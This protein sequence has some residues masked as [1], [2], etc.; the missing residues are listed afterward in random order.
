M[1]GCEVKNLGGNPN[2]G[3]ERVL[4]GW[5]GLGA[6]LGAASAL[7]AAILAGL[8]SLGWVGLLGAAGGYVIGVG[9]GHAVEWFDRLKEQDP[10]EI[11]ISGLIVC[12]G[13][14]TG[15]PPFN[16]NDWTFNVGSLSVT[17]PT[18]L[19]VNEVRTRPAPPNW[20]AFPSVDDPSEVD[21]L[22]CEIGSHIGDF[23][24]VGGAVG[25]VAGA[26]AG[27][28]I[29]AALGCLVLGIFTFGLGC[30]IAILIG[31]AVGALVGLAAGNAIGAG[32]GWIADELSDFDRRGKAIERGCMLFLTGSWV[33]DAGHQHNEIHD[34]ERATLIDCGITSS[35]RSLKLA[36]AVGTGR[37]P[38]DRDP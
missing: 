5:G 14:N 38:Q 25:S 21:V 9:I 27:A 17:G 18:S 3:L 26:L 16:D 35:S 24:A 13:K 34:I 31:A 32:L 20:P 8:G 7:T 22:H 12:A 15:F 2:W 37:H 30:L 4:L 23:A 19:A 28:A 11:T 33:N 6:T 10:K 36:A 1:A 29:G